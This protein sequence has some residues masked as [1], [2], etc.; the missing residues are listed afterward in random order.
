[1]R[2]PKEVLT[3]GEVA[4]IC[5]VAPRTVSKW[6]DSGKLRGYRIPGSKDRRIPLDQ[7]VRFMKAH[8]MPLEGLDTGL[9]R[10]LIAERDADLGSALTTVLEKT[11]G[12]QVT[13]VRSAFEAGAKSEA[14]GPQV[15]L[16]D[17]SMPGF[18]GRETVRSIRNIA[19]LRDCSLIAMVERSAEGSPEALRQ[20]GFDQVL[21]KPFDSTTMMAAIDGCLASFVAANG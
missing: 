5:N 1:M 8:S 6:F 19:N 9:V 20:Q 18:A 3:T 21:E 10:V 4:K 2:Q 13:L 11:P 17:V 15:M 12:F 7:L 16:V 14:E